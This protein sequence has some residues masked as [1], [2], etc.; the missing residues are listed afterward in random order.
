MA[1]LLAYAIY[2]AGLPLKLLIRSNILVNYNFNYFKNQCLVYQKKP[3]DNS[4]DGGFDDIGH[5]HDID[6][7]DDIDEIK[8]ILENLTVTSPDEIF[9]ENIELSHVTPEEE[10]LYSLIDGRYLVGEIMAVG[11]IGIIRNGK[12]IPKFQ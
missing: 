2:Y 7:I 8:R 4:N 5:I 6:N 12:F 3:D 11:H 9:E 1:C 10:L